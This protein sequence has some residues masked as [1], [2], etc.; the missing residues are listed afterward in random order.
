MLEV[1][2]LDTD[3]DYV[4]PFICKTCCEEVFKEGTKVD[5]SRAYAAIQAKSGRYETWFRV[6]TI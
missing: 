5:I 2:N 1:Q 3:E 4:A 6:S